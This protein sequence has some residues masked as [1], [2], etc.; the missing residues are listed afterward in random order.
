M[1]AIGDLRARTQRKALLGDDEATMVFETSKSV[2]VVSTFDQMNLRDDLLRG[3]Y[4]YGE[5]TGQSHSY[6]FAAV[7]IHW[8]LMT[9]V[10]HCCM[11]TKWL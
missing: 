10:H 6:L 3:I 11:R 5:S 2:S 7:T 8:G 4:A 9:V 1:A